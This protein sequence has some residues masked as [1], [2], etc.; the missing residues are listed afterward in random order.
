MG[1]E[2]GQSIVAQRR[3]LFSCSTRK[4]RG[5]PSPTRGD[6]KYGPN[7]K[8][9]TRRH[10]PPT[11]PPCPNGR[12]R[13]SPFSFC[14]FASGPPGRSSWCCGPAEA[15]T[16]LGGDACRRGVLAGHLPLL[17]KPMRVYVFGHELTH[18]I[19]TWL[20]GGRVKRFKATSTGGHVVDHEE[21]FL[22]TLAPYFFPL[23]VVLVGTG[24]CSRTF[25]LGLDA[26]SGLVPPA[27]GRS[28]RFSRHVD[29]A[30]FA[31]AADR[32]SRSRVICFR[33]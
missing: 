29:L 23:Y 11:I 8:R 10:R 6:K 15:R 14:R 26:V 18:A 31:N 30:Y 1:T 3:R 25:G 24:V 32:T 9:L 17:P 12:R 7:E 2:S 4:V 28:L 21:Q 22:I 27:G 33:P 16:G 20:F 5:C 13:S 19:W